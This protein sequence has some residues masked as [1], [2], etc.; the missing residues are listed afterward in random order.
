MRFERVKHILNFCGIVKKKTKKTE[1]SAKVYPTKRVFFFFVKF[2]DE[3][4]ERGEVKVLKE[5]KNSLPKKLCDLIS[6]GASQKL[7]FLKTNFIFLC[8]LWLRD[9]N[10]DHVGSC[11]H[12]S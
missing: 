9:M 11:T 10:V 8:R 7:N 1:N 6:I 3:L 2:R 12:F 4:Q 5:K